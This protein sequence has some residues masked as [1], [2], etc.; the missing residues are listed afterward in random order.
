MDSAHCSSMLQALFFLAFVWFF[1]YESVDGASST[2]KMGNFS[3]VEDAVNFHIYYGQTFKV[4]KNAVD[5]QSYLLL[6]VL[7]CSHI[8][9]NHWQQLGFWLFFFPLNCC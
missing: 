6:Q 9:R 1:N 4:I 3:K 8:F 7:N 2:V 5:G